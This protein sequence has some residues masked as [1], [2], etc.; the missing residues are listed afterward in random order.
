[1]AIGKKIE[2]RGHVTGFREEIK[3]ASRDS[4][5][6]FFTWFNSSANVVS[7]FGKGGADFKK[8]ILEPLKCFQKERLK[9]KRAI[10]IGHGGGRL[11][12]AASDCFQS[13]VGID[14]HECNDVVL[15]ELRRRGK[16]NVELIKLDSGDGTIPLAGESFDI[17]YSFI[18]LQHVEKIIILEKYI[19]EAYRVLRKGGYAVLYFGRYSFFS[20]GR[21]K[22]V[23]YLLDSLIEKFFLKKGYMEIKTKV[24]EV[25]LFVSLDHAIHISES[26]G[27]EICSELLSYRYGVDGKFS[28]MGGQNGLVLKKN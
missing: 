17:V 14:I 25:N 27:F 12:A 20:K 3:K 2:T 21:K 23:F 1:M 11:I 6:A 26:A 5:L 16:K 13:V 8:H 9:G 24:N 7:S 10:E 19:R 18:V 15:A 28:L 22:N 4:E